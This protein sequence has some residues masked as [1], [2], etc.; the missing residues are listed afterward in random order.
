MFDNESNNNHK[1]D[2]KRI[3]EIK[4]IKKEEKIDKSNIK[5]QNICENYY[6][7]I[8]NLHPL[9]SLFRIS[10]I[11]PLNLR[12]YFFTFNNLILFGFN[13]LLYL[14]SDIEK[15]I[16]DNQRNSFI[17]PMKKEYIKIILSILCQ[18][19]ITFILKIFMTAPY[20]KRKELFD[21]I[22]A[23]IKEKKENNI[24]KKIKN[25]ENEFIL[26]RTILGFIMILI[27]GFFYYYCTGFC[28]IY[29][30]TKTNWFYSGIWSLLINWIILS[31]IYIFIISIIDN[32]KNNPNNCLSYNLKRLFFF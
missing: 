9:F 19:I 28:D 20:N 14:E 3:I 11:Y 15:R 13:A 10:I 16:Y 1:T 17:Y 4:K 6:E 22:N 24:I 30:N 12:S 7:N 2:E 27:I 23:E 26:R 8:K 29:L 21:E 25:F 32:L 5:R 18:I 31:P